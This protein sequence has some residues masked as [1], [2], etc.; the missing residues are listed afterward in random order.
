MR[1]QAAFACDQHPDPFACNKYL[2]AYSPVFDDYGL[3]LHDMRATVEIAY[4]PW[5]G[6]RLPKGRR[7]EYFRLL[8]ELGFGDAMARD[9]GLPI[10]QQP[11]IPADFRSDLWWRRRA[12]AKGRKA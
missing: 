9:D 11:D 2:I 3:V 7:R 8:E 12:A 4:C 6:T 5:C 10:E 1:H